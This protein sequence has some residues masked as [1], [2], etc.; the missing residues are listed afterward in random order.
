MRPISRFLRR[1]LLP[2]PALAGL[3]LVLGCNK[4]GSRS[5]VD[6]PRVEEPS[7]VTGFLF[8]PGGAPAA[9][10]KAWIFP[11]GRL[12]SPAATPWEEDT[13][14][15]V[16][17]V[18]ADSAGRYRILSL[19]RGLYNVVAAWDTLS[20]FQDSVF[21]GGGKYG[22][23]RP[24]T[25]HPPGFLSG[26]IRLQPNHAPGQAT[27]R[28][29]GAPYAA[30]VDSS[31]RFILGPVPDG[32]YL[33]R[34]EAGIPGYSALVTPA[35]VQRNRKDTLI[36]PI[37]PPFLGIPAVA[38]LAAALDTASG[39]VT[40]RW[41]RADH[42]GLKEYVLFRD[43][44]GKED[45]AAT[46]WAE[47][48]DTFF[49]DTVFGDAS[50]PRRFPADDTLVRTL[51]YRIKARDRADSLGPFLEKAEL[52]APSPRMI[53]SEWGFRALNGLHG[54]SGEDTASIKDTV[55]CEISFLNRFRDVRSVE[56]RIGDSLS[57]R[58]ET[59][60]ARSGKDTVRFICPGY[61]G[62]VTIKA[63]MVDEAGMV[64]DT[65]SRLRVILDPPRV[66]AIVDSVVPRDTPFRLRATVTQKF[67]TLTKLEWDIGSTGI[68]KP[69]SSLDTL[70][71]I[72]APNPSWK[73]VIRAMDDD[74]MVTTDTIR[75]SVSRS[76][77]KSPLPRARH[78][79]GV[80]VLNGMLL[81]A[82]AVEDSLAN[83]VD[84]YDPVANTWSALPSLPTPRGGAAVCT[85]QNSLYV[86]GGLRNGGKEPVAAVEE[87][88]PV[89][90]AWTVKTSLPNAMLSVS[91]GSSGGRIHV[92]GVREK[93][94]NPGSGEGMKTL[95]TEVLQYDPSSN[96]WIVLDS[97]KQINAELMGI[98]SGW[99]LIA[100]Q[101]GM[102]PYSD[103]PFENAPRT[104]SRVLNL[105]PRV[106]KPSLLD[107]SVKPAYGF[108]GAYA[109]Y[110]T[111]IYHSGWDAGSG[112]TR[113]VSVLTIGSGDV[114]TLLPDALLARS[115]HGAGIIGNRMYLV[116]GRGPTRIHDSVEEYLLP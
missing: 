32:D 63:R 29:L 72:A 69:A 82:G 88:N 74:S 90:N 42:H 64:R 48:R 84:A 105:D 77:F 113:S 16:L 34:I 33:L 15:G 44:A 110:Q 115:S 65:V 25:L 1:A 92:V 50:R 99:L 35:R 38:G 31:G 93:P 70:L 98:Q 73:T 106:P 68:F 102:P 94:A 9:G 13:T 86:I 5:M 14:G 97:S 22:S 76:K 11:V 10:A 47:T 96:G 39:V 108:D 26:E 59:H 75:V 43:Q 2:I 71:T 17:A 58:L 114:W 6:P 36:A 60:G 46:A 7:G 91:A 85:L 54:A 27:I 18:T 80:A 79:A 28:A 83:R 12:P 56:W 53:R 37:R 112:P 23:L 103:H 30:T 101:T 104:K 87:F 4:D 55:R 3:L 95:F 24:D 8:L 89:S 40:I 45:G 41:K 100:A 19:S 62:V 57:G 52:A 78:G 109:T 66:K 107:R 67:G 51:V 61:D 111:R 116:G 21:H 20:A 49:V 81:V